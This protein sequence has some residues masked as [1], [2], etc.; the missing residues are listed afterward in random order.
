M[1]NLFYC[2][3][4]RMEN[5]NYVNNSIKHDWFESNDM[6]SAFIQ[7]LNSN[8]AFSYQNGQNSASKSLNTLHNFPPDFIDFV[9]L[10]GSSS[11]SDDWFCNEVN[12]ESSLRFNQE[13]CCP[14][15][16]TIPDFK[17]Q[18]VA[19]YEEAMRNFLSTSINQCVFCPDFWFNADN[20]NVQNHPTDNTPEVRTH[21]VQNRIND[22]SSLNPKFQ[23]SE[24]SLDASANELSSAKKNFERYLPY[25]QSPDEQSVDIKPIAQELDEKVKLLLSKNSPRDLLSSSDTKISNQELYA[26]SYKN[27]FNI[28]RAETESSDISLQTSN[29]EN[30]L[31]DFNKNAR[32]ENLNLIPIEDFNENL[33]PDE[34]FRG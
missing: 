27:D 6:V 26:S 28:A 1:D 19:L 31:L 5:T 10:D 15:E 14:A 21:A 4:C 3:H 20:A 25:A 11:A 7:T 16:L 33:S 34:R 8:Q 30:E 22:S 29:I 9:D 23:C 32:E 12:T 24:F 2:C 17:D 13:D 18:N